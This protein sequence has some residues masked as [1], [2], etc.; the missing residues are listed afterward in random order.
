MLIA[1]GGGPTTYYQENGRHKA[2]ATQILH[3]INHGTLA[4]CGFDVHEPYV[5][6]NVLGAGNEG[7][8]K[9]LSDLQYRLENLTKSPQ[10]LVKYG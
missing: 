9:M 8:T 3:P 10:W 1:A 5:A 7:R 4:F 6:L 2:T